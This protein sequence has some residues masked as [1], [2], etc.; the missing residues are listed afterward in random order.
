[1]GLY[2][3]VSSLENPEKVI[4][5]LPKIGW[6]KAATLVVPHLTNDNADELMKDVQQKVPYDKL[7]KTIETKYTT[8]GGTNARGGTAHTRIR[9]SAFNFRLFEDQ[10]LAVE[11]ILA[12]AKKQT[13]VSDDNQLFEHIVSEW[14]GDHLGDVA[15]KAK[16]QAE[17][18]FAKLRKEGVKIPENH[19]QAAALKEAAE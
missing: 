7:K 18:R 13:G 3:T 11:T 1:M 12:A 19:P 4:R 14:A 16:Q 10:A 8:A 2:E 17:K 15:A 6:W 5:E 9:M